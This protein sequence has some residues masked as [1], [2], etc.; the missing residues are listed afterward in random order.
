MLDALRTSG[1]SELQLFLLGRSHLVN[2]TSHLVL[3][4]RT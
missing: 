3:V 4:Q 1:T 2:P